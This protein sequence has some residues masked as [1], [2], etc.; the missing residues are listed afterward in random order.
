MV[1]SRMLGPL[2]EEEKQDTEMTYREASWSFFTVCH[3]SHYV[4]KN[5]IED[6]QNKQSTN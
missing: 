5:E 2:R 1:L 4:R 3:E 6:M